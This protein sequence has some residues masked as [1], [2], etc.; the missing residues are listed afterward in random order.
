MN[1][2]K[3]LFLSAM[4]FAVL[5]CDAAPIEIDL[6]EAHLILVRPMDQWSGLRPS[7]KSSI[8]QNSEKKYF[9]RYFDTN[10]GKIIGSKRYI[11]SGPND[12]GVFKKLVES[13]PDRI[14]NSNSLQFDMSKPAQLENNDISIF[15]ELQNNNFQTEVI[16]FGDPDT[17]PDRFDKSLNTLLI[18]K[19]ITATQSIKHGTAIHESA[20]S[21]INS[22]SAPNTAS[23][24]AEL[25]LVMAKTGA[26]QNIS[27]TP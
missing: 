17:L 12:E 11:F 16:K 23:L 5:V 6:P 13:F 22:K 8:L 7:S 21:S 10:S 27:Y 26:I 3:L 20:S 9:L 4:S 18:A 19:F 2:A 24:P 14:I 15:L 1:F 25:S